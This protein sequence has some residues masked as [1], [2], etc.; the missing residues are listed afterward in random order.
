MDLQV[1]LVPPVVVREEEEPEVIGHEI[2]LAI[3]AEL[4]LS[5]FL[6]EQVVLAAAPR[7]GGMILP[8]QVTTLECPIQQM[9]IVKLG[10]LVPAGK[11]H[12]EHRLGPIQQ[13]VQ[14]AMAEQLLGSRARAAAV[15]AAVVVQPAQGRTLV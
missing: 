3:L 4:T 6:L 5:S 7:Y 14:A 13:A 8:G 2:P 1:Q 11:L 15:A 10:L 12:L 9:P